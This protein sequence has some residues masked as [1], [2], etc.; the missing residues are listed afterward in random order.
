MS[1]AA[2]TANHFDLNTLWSLLTAEERLS[3]ARALVVSPD[4][5][6]KDDAKKA[7]ELL[8][9][10]MNFRPQFVRNKME[11]EAVAQHLAK[12]LAQGRFEQS[13]APAIR[14]FLLKDHRSLIISFLDAMPVKHDKGIIAP[15]VISI[16]PKQIEK[17]IK[18]LQ[19]NHPTKFTGIYLGY[20]FL[21]KD[22]FWE[23]FKA[24]PKIQ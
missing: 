3:A 8:A 6:N 12:R 15:E 11:K 17:G 2:K 22:D 18:H 20:L 16:E 23:S 7:M 9:E 24:F 4:D 10:A 5:Y 21:R 14:A 13:L 1:T 19:A